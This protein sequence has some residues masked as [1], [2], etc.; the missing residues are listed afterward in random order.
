MKIVFKVKEKYNYSQ[1][2]DV[3]YLLNKEKEKSQNF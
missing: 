3:T 2:D 1:L